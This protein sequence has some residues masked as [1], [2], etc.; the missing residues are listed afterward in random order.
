MN[1]KSLCSKIPTTPWRAEFPSSAEF[2]TIVLNLPLKSLQ[3]F[4]TIACSWFP[5]LV[6]EVLPCI[7]NVLSVGSYGMNGLSL[8]LISTY[9]FL[10]AFLIAAVLCPRCGN[11]QS[12]H[13]LLQVKLTMARPGELVG[14]GWGSWPHLRS[15]ELSSQALQVM[16]IDDIFHRIST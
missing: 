7:I 10:T 6:N 8:T 12:R 13:L 16:C 11:T 5:T 9:A 1:I 3:Q 4:L 15:S 14:K 2:Y